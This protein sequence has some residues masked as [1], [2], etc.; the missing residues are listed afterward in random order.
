MSIGTPTLDVNFADPKVLQDPYP[1]FDAIRAAGPAVY[2]EKAGAWMVASYEHVK[3]VLLDDEHFVP[4][5]DKWETLY[6]GAVVE[7]LEEPRHGEVRSA[8]APMFRASY[9]RKIR[10]VIIDLITSRLDNIAERL[11]E[12]EVIDVVPEVA[13]AV[14]G[15][16]LAHIL[17]VAEEDVPR[18]LAWA[19]DMGATLESY[20]EPD[21]GRA[22]QLRQTGTEATKM[23]CAFAGHQL[24]AR[25]G[26]DTR[27]DL[28]AQFAR[29]PIAQT[30]SERDQKA[31]IAQVIVAGH[32]N[33]TH[34]LGHVFVALALHPE[35]REMLAADRS[36]IPQAVEELLRW[37]TSASGDTRLVRGKARI[38]DVELE[39]GDRVMVLLAAANR[40]P[41]RWHN[42]DRFDITRPQQPHITFGAGV[43]TCLGSGIG[44][45]ESQVMMEEV[46]NRLPSFRLADDHIEY[47][48]PLFMRGPKQVRIT[49]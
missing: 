3:A 7:S 2:N 8:L 42:P 30:M 23:T 39:D 38:G 49:L 37:R 45:L 44:R 35:Q 9:L 27:Q 5:A 22:A 40:D 43:H 32:D 31:T 13:R 20:D 16:V 25:R 1:L 4:E 17:G 26:D 24:E 28:I 36:L 34:T 18:F 6:G 46:L 19:K 41:S 12:G 11:H 10:P 15:R 47:G 33:I 48:A 21:P 29:S 14:A